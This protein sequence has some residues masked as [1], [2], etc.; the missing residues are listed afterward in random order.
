MLSCH[1]PGFCHSKESMVAVETGLS[2]RSL[3][4]DAVSKHSEYGSSAHA[5]QL[6]EQGRDVAGRMERIK[7]AWLQ[8]YFAE[9]E[10]ADLGAEGS[11]A[12]DEDG[13]LGVATA[14]YSAT[15][16]PARRSEIGMNP[17]SH[18]P[19]G[20]VLPPYRQEA[21]THRDADGAT[22]LVAGMAVATAPPPEPGPPMPP[23]PSYSEAAAPALPGG[24]PPPPYSPLPPRAPTGRQALPPAP[25]DAAG[26]AVSAPAVSDAQ[27]RKAVAALSLGG[28][29]S[30]TGG[31]DHSS[32]DDSLP[33]Y[34]SSRAPAGT[35]T[36]PAT[37]APYGHPGA[38]YPAAPGTAGSAVALP[39]SARP[40][41]E[42][43]VGDPLDGT[44][45]WRRGYEGG[46]GLAELK[47]GGILK[48]VL[49]MPTSDLGTLRSL[50]IPMGIIDAFIAMA[51]ANSAVPPRGVETCG[52]LAG[53]ITPHGHVTMTTLVVADQKGDADSCE[54]TDAGEMQVFE[55]CSSRDLI[56]MGWI[57]THPSQECF[58]SSYDVRTHLGFQTM[59]H[60]AVAIVAA[61]RDPRIR[62]GVFRLIE[63]D[64][65]ELVRSRPTDNHY[66]VPSGVYIYETTSH[67]RMVQGRARHG[68]GVDRTPGGLGRDGIPLDGE[69]FQVIDM[70]GR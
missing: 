53:K 25:P 38:W 16:N 27:W 6:V 50:Y 14:G 13:L 1:K 12:L 19:A 11:D 46:R 10:L 67:V 31:P 7:D 51:A 48:N 49:R 65:F 35:A 39:Q 43:G 55:A 30:A 20:A 37:A 18:R 21:A 23:L 5:K 62:Y 2:D 32:A 61:P 29:S 33:A 17:A 45:G 56:Q 58:M 42:A 57:H 70:R 15:A 41:P 64:G 22:A 54:L 63:P 60:E 59:L 36:S 9:M 47:C 66:H 52:I 44:M 34:L 3:A 4:I 40:R 24:R 26:R 68:A 28:A 8:T 69:D